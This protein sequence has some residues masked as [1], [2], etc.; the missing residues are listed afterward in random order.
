MRATKIVCTLLALC[1][2][3]M[4]AGRASAGAVNVSVPVPRINVPRVNVQSS[5]PKISVPTSV[6]P[7]VV[8]RIDV[9]RLN[10]Q[11]SAPKVSVPTSVVPRVAPKIDVSKYKIDISKKHEA[12]GTKLGSPAGDV[13]S[14]SAQQGGASGGGLFPQSL[15][16]SWPGGTPSDSGGASGGGPLDSGV[17]SGRGPARYYA[18]ASYSGNPTACGHYPYPRCK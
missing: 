9:P 4:A 14:Q 16:R 2:V 13:N 7:R 15:S 5:V 17:P 11:S 18:P 6:V 10:V 1:I 8:P 12:F 3:F